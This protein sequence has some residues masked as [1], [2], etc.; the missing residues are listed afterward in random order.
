MRSGGRGT[1]C[2]RPGPGPRHALA[3][4]ALTGPDGPAV[5]WARDVA[6]ELGIDL[7]A[8]SLTEVTAEGRHHNTSV[9]VG[10]DGEVHA[11]Y[12]KIHLFDVEVAGRSYRESDLEEP[13][14]EVVTSET[15]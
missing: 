15:T 6:R 4:T 14:E 9:H 1:P 12:R 8:G 3:T 5:S 10:S 11:I 13:G 7:V 2:G